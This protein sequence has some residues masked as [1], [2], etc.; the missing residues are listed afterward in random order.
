MLDTELFQTLHCTFIFI[1]YFVN[2][3]YQI[4]PN[5]AIIKRKQAFECAEKQNQ[6]QENVHTYNENEVSPMMVCYASIN[7]DPYV[8]NF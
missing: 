3:F 2:S 1:V 4:R 6:Y 8:L 5:T 7:S